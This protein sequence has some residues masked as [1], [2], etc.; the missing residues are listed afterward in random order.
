[1]DTSTILK[2]WIERQG[3]DE[4]SLKDAIKAMERRD[5][6]GAAVKMALGRFIDNRILVR[7]SHGWYRIIS[8]DP[9]MRLSDNIDMEY[10]DFRFPM[11]L[12]YL[13]KIS[14][15]SVILVA[16]VPNSGK[17]AFLLDF[18][19]LN[20]FEHTIRYLSSEL[21]EVRI[22]HR[23]Q[24]TDISLD[25]WVRHVKFYERASRFEDYAAKYCD[26]VIIVDYLEMTDDFYAVGKYI[27]AMFRALDKGVVLIALQKN[28]GQKLGVGR[29]RSSEKPHLYITLDN[30]V[31]TIVK[32]K[33]WVNLDVNPN[34]MRC[35]FNI[36]KGYNFVQTSQWIGAGQPW[37]RRNIDAEDD[38]V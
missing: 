36:E 28:E 15:K 26:D 18:C 14:P 3:E 8:I 30:E 1:M 29:E 4:F 32:G 25:E 21:N 38:E 16:G 12:E 7:T 6:T 10:V 23:L 37:K 35:R 22:K 9:P 19:R 17:S 31:F 20:M 5:I 11:K 13:V 2:G 34:G 33:E 27:N 24:F